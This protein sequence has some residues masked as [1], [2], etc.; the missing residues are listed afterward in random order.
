MGISSRSLVPVDSARI[1]LLFLQDG[2]Y[3]E[4]DAGYEGGE[5]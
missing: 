4:E 5:G 3:Q 1:L 2:S